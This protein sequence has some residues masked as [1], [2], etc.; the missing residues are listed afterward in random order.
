MKTINHEVNIE[1]TL[2]DF[3]LV[4]ETDIHGDDDILLLDCIPEIA[5]PV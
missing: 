5:L 4:K 1:S 3:L 2:P